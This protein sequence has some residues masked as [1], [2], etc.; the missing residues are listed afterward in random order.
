[1]TTVHKDNSS[2]NSDLHYIQ[3]CWS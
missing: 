3:I 2:C 1:M